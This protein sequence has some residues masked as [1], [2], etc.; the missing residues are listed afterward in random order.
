[1]TATAGIACLA[2]ELSWAAGTPATPIEHV[3]VVIGENQTFDAVFATYVPRPGSTVRN[4]LSEGIVNADGTPGPQFA[5]AKQ[6][7]GRPQTAYTLDPPRA[8][9]YPS[10]PQ[11]RLIGVRDQTFRSVGHGV[12]PRFPADLP[13]GPF[14]ITRYVP[15]PHANA[16]PT[17]SSSTAA[18]SASTGDPV[19]RFFQMWQQTGGDNSRLD[20]HTWVAVTTGMGADTES[21]TAADTGQG[22]EL[23]GF[24]NMHAGDA[25]YLRELADRYAISD[26]YHQSVMGGTG[27]NFFSIATADVARYEILIPPPVR[28]T[29]TGRTG[30]RAVPTW[31]ARMRRSPAL[32]LF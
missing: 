9:P 30:T 29:S 15:Y 22:G 27:A 10:L 17:L 20:L 6:A 1:M 19:H 13:N 12:D 2:A 7:K 31:S 28:T 8:D 3:I 4:L 26:N 5:L 32:G 25:G 18:L 16:T 23:M 24:V 11:P 14:Q 21:V